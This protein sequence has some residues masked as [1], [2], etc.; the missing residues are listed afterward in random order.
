MVFLAVSTLAV[1]LFTAAAFGL[2]LVLDQAPG[3]RRKCLLH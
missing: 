3:R 1:T 2:V